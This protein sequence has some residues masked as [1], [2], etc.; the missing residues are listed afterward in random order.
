MIFHSD[1]CC[2]PLLKPVEFLIKLVF[3]PPKFFLFFL[4]NFVESKILELPYDFM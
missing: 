4:L 1:L 3:K 2:N